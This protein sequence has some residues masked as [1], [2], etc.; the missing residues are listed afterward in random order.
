[1][2][3]DLVDQSPPIIMCIGGIG[4]YAVCALSNILAHQQETLA[5]KH[6]KG[7]K[8][9]DHSNSQNSTKTTRATTKRQEEQQTRHYSG[10]HHHSD[11]DI[12]S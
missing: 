4:T 6:N 10:N 11:I 9:N 12:N 5:N 1:M 2:S 7:H 8:E 3:R